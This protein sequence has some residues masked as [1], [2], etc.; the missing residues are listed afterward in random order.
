MVAFIIVCLQD[1]CN[2]LKD[3]ATASPA[4][5][6]FAEWCE[7][8]PVDA[9]WRGRFKVSGSCGIICYVFVDRTCLAG[10][11]LLHQSGGARHA[12]GDRRI[13]RET[14]PDPPHRDNLSWAKLPGDEYPRT[15]VRQ[16]GQTVH[17]SDLISLWTDVHADR[18]RHRGP[19]RQGAP[20]G[21]VCMCGGQQ[22][23]GGPGRVHF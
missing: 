19:G 7:K 11:Q 5:R 15:Q 23:T 6:L 8:A 22:A 2:Q 9:A 14:R 21:H 12:L 18:L 1:A 16:P 20:G 13:Q 10:H 3:L 4:V 17:L